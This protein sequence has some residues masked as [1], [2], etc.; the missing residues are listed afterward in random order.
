MA[1]PQIIPALPESSVSSF[2]PTPWR[3]GTH[4]EIVTDSTKGLR[5]DEDMRQY[6]GGNLVAES[7]T[8]ENAR[9]IV[10][11]VN[12]LAGIPTEILEQKGLIG[13]LEILSFRATNKGE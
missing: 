3:V 1:H 7:I 9:R 12:A 5:C 11:C 6:Y 8:K 4:G 2:T 10:A 13:I